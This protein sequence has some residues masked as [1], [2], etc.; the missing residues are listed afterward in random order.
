MTC[1]KCGQTWALCTCPGPFSGQPTTDPWTGLSSHPEHEE[2]LPRPGHQIP[3]PGW[4]RPNCECGQID[5]FGIKHS[6]YCRLSKH[7][8]PEEP[9]PILFDNDGDDW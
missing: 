2:P 7:P 9:L 3:I 8:N 1:P 4:G 5:G 6:D